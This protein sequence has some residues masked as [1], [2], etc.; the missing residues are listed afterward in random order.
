MAVRRSREGFTLVE[1]LVVIAI[2]ALLAALLLPALKSAREKARRAVCAS[3]LRQWALAIHGY[4]T[5]NG[6]LLSSARPYL[7]WGTYPSTVRTDAI[8]GPGEF[9]VPLMA[10]YAPGAD[11]AAQTTRGI[12]RCPTSAG[13][14]K[15]RFDMTY[16]FFHSDY[17]YFAREDLWPGLARFPNEITARELTADRLLFADQIFRWN[18]YPGMP[19][20]YNHGRYGPSI[21][22]LAG[23]P[24]YYGPPSLDGANLLYGD[25]HSVWKPAGQYDANALEWSDTWPTMGRI[26]GA[27]WDFTFY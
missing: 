7:P 1:L 2:I 4:A 23:S 25:G 14:G 9:S 12:W 19:W 10:T 11:V 13:T 8:S 21:H 27:S 22:P 15:V 5:D 17:S 20:I 3:N 24:T 6:K 16:K 26:A 18:N